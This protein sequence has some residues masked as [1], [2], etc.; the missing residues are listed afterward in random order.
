MDNERPKPPPFDIPDLELPVARARQASRAPARS[1]ADSRLRAP[2]AVQASSGAI[3]I[4]P[5]VDDTRSGP[6]ASLGSGSNAHDYFGA[7]MFDG[8][9]GDDFA[10]GSL[11]TLDLQ[12]AHATPQ[13]AGPEWPSGRSPERGALMI[14]D[15]EVRLAGAYPTPASNPLLLPLY[16][17]H[18]TVRRRSLRELLARID[19]E[20]L[21]TEQRRDE[22][23]AA[24][25]NGLRPVLENE[26][27]LAG[28]LVAA[29]QLGEIPVNAGRRF[30]LSMSNIKE[31]APRPKPGARSNK[32]CS[33]NARPSSASARQSCFSAT[34]ATAARKPARSAFRSRSARRSTWRGK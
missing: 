23:L 4:E 13:A 27:R 1:P 28:L 8:E 5:F 2:Q 30:A 6:R 32:A 7:G 11:V 29:R 15:A 3:E 16:S 21:A 26:P 25:V 9:T 19:R 34:R 14:A 12:G 20:L 24:M 17:W 10:P 22:L 31:L 18:V 33:P